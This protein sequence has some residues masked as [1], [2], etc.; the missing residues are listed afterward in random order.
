MHVQSF[1]IWSMRAVKLACIHQY[2]VCPYMQ[3]MDKAFGR[4]CWTYA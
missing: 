4:C 1:T 2:I 3:M